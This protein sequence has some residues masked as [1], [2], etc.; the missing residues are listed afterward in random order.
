MDFAPFLHVISAYGYPALFLLIL[1]GGINIPIPAGILLLAVG[2]LAREGYINPFIALV[3]VFVAS[4]VADFAVYSLARR[5]GRN[6]KFKHFFTRSRFGKPIQ[7][8]LE[9]YPRLTIFLTRIIGVATTPTN[10]LAG[11]SRMKISTFSAAAVFGN[12]V[13]DGLYLF[14]GYLAGGAFK[15]NPH[16]TLEVI[17]I[18]VAI[19]V[20]AGLV[21]Y[22]LFRPKSKKD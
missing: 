2:A 16:G 6:E 15:R 5:F 8:Y 4:M 11:L 3:V 20:V 14:V 1:L 7:Q 9:K 13:A 19:V 21:G 12:I 18:I 10:A 22:F 17:G